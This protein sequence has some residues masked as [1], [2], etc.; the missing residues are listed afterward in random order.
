MKFFSKKK[1]DKVTHGE[2]K[3]LFL[4][5]DKPLEL[6]I[7][8][9]LHEVN[10]PLMNAEHLVSDLLRGELR[11]H[12]RIRQSLEGMEDSIN[13]IIALH[14]FLLESSSLKLDRTLSPAFCSLNSLTEAAVQMAKTKSTYM[15][16]NFKFSYSSS[17]NIL[18]NKS[19]L[20][21]SITNI[22]LNSIESCS[23]LDRQ[24][25]VCL[26]TKDFID[27]NGH[28]YTKLEIFNNGKFISKEIQETISL[29]FASTKNDSLEHGLSVA[30]KLIK[31]NGGTIQ[32][33]SPYNFETSNC[34]SSN[35]A[36]FKI[37]FKQ[38]KRI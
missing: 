10:Y 33:E 38:Q 4:R 2:K 6:V 12:K 27:K 23:N 26:S 14:I 18:C 31:E 20:L 29:P 1:N 7:S 17:C 36:I 5:R 15:G 11:D 16:I 37:L 22:V 25:L 21:H 19:D 3:E 35:G 9:F 28:H 32:V 30:I 34:D 24:G 8:H 13:R